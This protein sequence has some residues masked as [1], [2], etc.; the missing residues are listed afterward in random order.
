MRIDQ[1]TCELAPLAAAE[2]KI[3]NGSG[4]RIK[5]RHARGKIMLRRLCIGDRIRIVSPFS[6][7]ITDG[8]VIKRDEI[9][10]TIAWDNHVWGQFYAD[11]PLIWDK[12]T[13]QIRVILYAKEPV[14][15]YLD[16]EAW[17][18]NLPRFG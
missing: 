11:S 2:V 14:V 8:Q 16:A 15:P 17:P 9:S 7:E 12:G 6:A 5:D 4:W 13:R 10:V 1:P 3:C 18:R